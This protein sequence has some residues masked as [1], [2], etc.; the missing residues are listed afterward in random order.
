MNR[1]HVNNFVHGAGQ[2]Y[3]GLFF[4][5]LQLFLRAT[6]DAELQQSREQPGQEQRCPAGPECPLGTHD[7]H[8]DVTQ[9]S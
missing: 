7:H 6:C 9:K 3:V 2:N 8:T 5:V 1:V 4:P